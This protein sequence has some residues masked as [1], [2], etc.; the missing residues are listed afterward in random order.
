VALTSSVDVVRPFETDRNR[1]KK[2]NDVDFRDFQFPSSSSSL[3][4]EHKAKESI[5][6][7]QS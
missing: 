5:W 6:K 7:K 2:L 4:G 3:G 1:Q